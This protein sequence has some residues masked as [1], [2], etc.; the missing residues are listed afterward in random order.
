MSDEADQELLEQLGR[1]A[2]RRWDAATDRRTRAHADDPAWTPSTDE[3]LIDAALGRLDDPEPARIIRPRRWIWGPA[4]ALVA[5]SLAWVWWRASPRPPAGLPAYEELS[6]EG[7]LS[8]VR[9]VSAAVAVPRLDGRALLRWRVVPVTAVTEAIGVWVHATGPD[10]RCLRITRGQR[11]EPTGAIELVGSVDEVLGLPPGEWTLTLL[12]AR[13]SD[14]SGLSSPC[15][16]DEHGAWLPGVRAA[17]SRRIEVV[18][19]GPGG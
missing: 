6:F 8:Q 13:R 12:V 7:G 5:A 1:R 2:R 11:I 10:D 4:A 18:A 16:Q 19:E 9:S 3:A 14:L 17:A 15:A